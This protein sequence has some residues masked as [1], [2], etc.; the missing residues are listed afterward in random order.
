MAPKRTTRSTPA[1]TTTPT[2]SMTDE[3]LKRLIA[4]GV[5]DVLAE[6]EA[7]RSGNGEDIH[8][9]GMGGRR[10]APLARECTEGVVEL[11]PWFERI[12]TVFC[13][14]N[15][16]VEN[17][18]K[19][20]TCTLLGCA[21]MWWNSHIRTAGH[22]VAMFPEESE[23]IKKYVGGLPDMIH[24]SIMA[25]KPKTMQDAIEFATELMDKKIR[26]FAERQSENKRKQDDNQQQQNK[27]KNTGRA[28]AAGSGEKKPYGGSKPLCSKCNYHHDGQCAPK[29]H[30]CNRVGHLARDCRST[31]NALLT[32]KGALGQC[33]KLK[34]NNR[35]NQG[36]NGN[37][38]AKVYAVGR[39]GTNPDSNVVT[40]TFLLN[41]RYASILFDTGADRSFVSTAFS[42]QFDITPT[43]LDHYYDV[44][45]A[46][47]RIIGLNAIIRGCTL[48]FLNHPFNIDLM[49][50]ELGSFDVIIGMDWLAKYQAV[51]VCAEKIVRIPWGNETLIVRGDGSDRGNETRLNIISCTKTQKYML[52]GCPIFLAHVTT[53]ETEDKSVIRAHPIDPKR[54]VQGWFSYK[55]CG[56]QGSGSEVE[57]GIFW[58]GIDR[59]YE[60]GYAQDRLAYSITGGKAPKN[61]DQEEKRGQAV[62]RELY[63]ASGYAFWVGLHICTRY[64][65]IW[66]WV[67]HGPERQQAAAAGTDKADEAGQ[68]A[69]KAAP[70]IPA[71]ASQHRAP[72]PPPP[73]QQP[74]TMSQKDRRCSRVG[75][76]GLS[77]R[78]RVRPKTGDASTS[79]AP[80][81]DAQP[82]P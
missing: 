78:R 68:A 39:A 2:T 33:P 26:T 37:A 69:E 29:C 19:F 59:P 22:D 56:G 43:T 16:S 54:V 15:C 27:R 32:T 8:G 40:G 72:P 36:G 55:R 75:S 46:D 6:C 1:T 18:I 34:N 82:D 67:A 57:D 51:I 80:H 71:P 30:K 79:V 35:G 5:A 12:E 77:F 21:L 13:I 44:E 74:Y 63:W 64:G 7:T 41:N 28:Y 14:S 31:A 9:S 11:S 38:L 60:R 73:S 47:G 49:P 25:S 70:E 61:V 50:V 48:N 65:E 52:K 53:K 81:T 76:S 10:Q 3:K 62:R 17:Q 4:Q 66:N 24:G 58:R 45:L 23:K 42:S 20:S